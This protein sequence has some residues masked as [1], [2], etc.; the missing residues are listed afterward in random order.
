[1]VV[2]EIWTYSKKFKSTPIGSYTRI[3]NIAMKISKRF[4][5]ARISE[6]V[7]KIRYIEHDLHFQR[8]Q[9]EFELQPSHMSS[10]EELRRKAHDKMTNQLF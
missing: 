7:K 3:R 8:R 5:L 1:M 4:L 2:E 6:N 9:L 10:V